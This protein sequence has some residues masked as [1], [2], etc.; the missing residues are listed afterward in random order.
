M[1]IEKILSGLR[2]TQDTTKEASAPLTLVS[3]PA[4][5]KTASDAPRDALVGALSTALAAAPLSEK[6]ASDKNAGPVADVMKVAEELAATEQEANIKH[7]Q[8]MGAAFADSFVAR[9][10]QW[11]TKA[12]E[13]LTTPAPA[14]PAAPAPASANTPPTYAKFAHENPGIIAQTQQ[15]GYDQTKAAL[16]KQANEAQVA[17]FNDAVNAIHKAASFE[18][19]KGAHV[20]SQVLDTALKG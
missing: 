12:A 11:Q 16:E 6:T 8:V 7:A 20:M 2:Q 15:L 4:A 13:L 10:G 14:A 1:K 19:I 3:P 9:L 5:D 17:G 18:F